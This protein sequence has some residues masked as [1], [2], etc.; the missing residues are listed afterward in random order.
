MEPIAS[1]VMY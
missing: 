1:P